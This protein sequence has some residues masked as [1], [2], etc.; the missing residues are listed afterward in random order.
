MKA[1]K[2]K[3]KAFV[4]IAAV[5]FGFLSVA[6]RAEGLPPGEL[7]V[8]EK[9]LAELYRDKS[10]IFLGERAKRAQAAYEEK[11]VQENFNT[12]IY[13]QLKTA[14]S[15]EKALFIYQSTLG[16]TNSAQLGIRK[17]FSHGFNLGA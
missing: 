12:E 16:P 11:S 7:L 10:V 2:S 6:A 4:V 13:S 15:S 1:E 8:S 5:L 3:L 14:D 17:N 9:S